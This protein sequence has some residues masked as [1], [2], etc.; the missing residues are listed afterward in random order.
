MG[1]EPTTETG[2]ILHQEAIRTFNSLVELRRLRAESISGSVPGVIWY[3][4]LLGA[5]F[6]IAAAFNGS[7]VLLECGGA[8]WIAGFACFAFMYGPALATRQPAWGKASG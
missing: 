4:V 1:F 5:L 2:K 8:L 6:R 3:V 7:I